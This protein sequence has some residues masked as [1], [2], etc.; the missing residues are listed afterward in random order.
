LLLNKTPSLHKENN[1]SQINYWV[2]GCYNH[3]VNLKKNIFPD[4]WEKQKIPPSKFLSHA[5]LVA[6]YYLRMSG[7]VEDILELKLGSIKG[8]IMSVKFRGQREFS[9]INQEPTVIQF[10]GTCPLNG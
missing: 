5:R 7:T 10:Q 1:L 4:L 3:P 2:E 9:Y 8:H 6:V